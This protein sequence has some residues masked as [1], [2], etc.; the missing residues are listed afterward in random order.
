LI[1]L[2]YTYQLI[3]ISPLLTLLF[4]YL[5]SLAHLGIISGS[6]RDHD[7]SVLQEEMFWKKCS[8]RSVLE[9]MFLQENPGRNLRIR[10]I[11]QLSICIP[12]LQALRDL[13]STGLSAEPRLIFGSELLMLAS[14]WSEGERAGWEIW[15]DVRDL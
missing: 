11:N 14:S 15:R 7:A 6:S 13:R 3:H 1:H 8:G 12:T 10:T 4:S 2:G 9:E 5:F